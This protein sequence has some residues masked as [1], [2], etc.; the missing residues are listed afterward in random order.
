MKAKQTTT[1]INLNACPEFPP[2]IGS[3]T[4]P[5]KPSKVKD[6]KEIKLTPDGTNREQRRAIV[7][8]SKKVGYEINF[9]ERIYDFPHTKDN[10]QKNSSTANLRHLLSGYGIAK[11][12]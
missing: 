7:S 3:T 9:D 1:E 5:K 12:V 6:K 10:G 4:P 11:A 8:F 2:P